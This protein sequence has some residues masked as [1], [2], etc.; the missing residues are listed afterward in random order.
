[1]KLNLNRCNMI[2]GPYSAQLDPSLQVICLGPCELQ[3]AEEAE[4]TIPGTLL[5][6]L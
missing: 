4:G 2:L 5:E 1:M 6:M 3:I